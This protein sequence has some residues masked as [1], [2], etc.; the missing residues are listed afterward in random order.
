MLLVSEGD[1]HALRLVADKTP[2]TAT[3][4]CGGYPH[5]S[6]PSLSPVAPADREQYRKNSGALETDLSWTDVTQRDP[7]MRFQGGR[8]SAI[9]STRHLSLRTMADKCYR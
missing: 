4:H 8:R 1:D 6:G 7:S 5:S 3:L 9:A 2:P